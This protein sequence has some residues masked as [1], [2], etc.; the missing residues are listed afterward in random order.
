MI[1]RAVIER[2]I[3][4][5]RRKSRIIHVQKKRNHL[6]WILVLVTVRNNSNDVLSQLSRGVMKNFYLEEK[7]TDTNN[8]N[9]ITSIIYSY[10]LK[11]KLHLHIFY[12]SKI[13][14]SY[15]F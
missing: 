11:Y 6:I 13:N 5:I 2:F 15:N 8:N 7:I 1:V 12:C 9:L 3:I 4:A 10:T 14:I